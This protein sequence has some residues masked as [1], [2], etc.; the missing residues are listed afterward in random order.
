MSKPL[1][2]QEEIRRGELLVEMLDLKPVSGM[3][4]WPARYHAKPRPKTALG[5]FRSIKRL[6]EDGE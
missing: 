5:L 3:E 1:S 6:I 4:E 2:E